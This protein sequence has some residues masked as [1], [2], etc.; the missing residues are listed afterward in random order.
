MHAS[1]IQDAVRVNCIAILKAPSRQLLSFGS[2]GVLGVRLPTESV[3]MASTTDS[4]QELSMK[5]EILPMNLSCGSTMTTELCCL[6]LR[7]RPPRSP[8]PIQL[9][10]M[11]RLMQIW[12]QSIRKGWKS[13]ILILYPKERIEYSI[14]PPYLVDANP[15]IWVTFN[16]IW[17]SFVCAS[18]I[19]D[20]DCNS[21]IEHV[22]VNFPFP[23]SFTRLLG[24]VAAASSNR[25]A[26]AA[27]LLTSLTVVKVQKATIGAYQHVVERI[28][29]DLNRSSDIALVRWLHGVHHH[30]RR[31]AA[32]AW[33]T[34]AA[35]ASCS[36]SILHKD[37]FL[38]AFSSKA[39]PRDENLNPNPNGFVGLS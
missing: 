26:A 25:C 37:V 18:T 20:L 8:N 14:M 22:H 30:Q 7:K 34:A 27:A 9:V 28:E 24:V 33:P 36:R 19:Y 16:F 15:N 38:S 35:Y 17:K 23:P 31:V 3:D 6:A 21:C 32:A 4:S 12:L 13:A 10:V 5:G 11:S 1:P 29:Y 39:R 2:N